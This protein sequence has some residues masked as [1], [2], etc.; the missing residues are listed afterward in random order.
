MPSCWFLSMSWKPCPTSPSDI[1]GLEALESPHSHD[2]GE[3]AGQT[4][5]EVVQVLA[6]PLILEC[7]VLHCQP[8]TLDC[9]FKHVLCDAVRPEIFWAVA[10]SCYGF[11]PVPDLRPSI[12]VY[13]A[14]HRPGVVIDEQAAGTERSPFVFADHVVL[15]CRSDRVCRTTLQVTLIINGRAS[16]PKIHSSWKLLQDLS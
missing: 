2:D 8:V 3:P 12:L 7:L 15:E 11:D 1:L 13:F 9:G 5:P 16:W 10:L 4:R 6:Q 14:L